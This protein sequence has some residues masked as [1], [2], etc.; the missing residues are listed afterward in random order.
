MHF[1][2]FRVLLIYSG[3]EFMNPEQEYSRRLER[4]RAEHDRA[5]QL[6]IT[7]GNIRFAVFTAAALIALLAFWR[8]A[9][10]FWWLLAPL[11][12]FIGLMIYHE[13]VDRRLRFADRAMRFYRRALARIHGEWIGTGQ[14]GERFQTKD[15]VYADDLDLFGRGSLFE[16]I[17]ET[18]TVAGEAALARW[19][20]QPAMRLEAME[21]QQA[22]DEL[23]NKLDLRED[24]ALL[25]EEI[26]AGVHAEALERWG[27]A[28][29]V[30]FHPLLRVT[31]LVLCLAGLAAFSAFMA[32]SI[33]LWP[34]LAILVLDFLFMIVV[35]KRV[36]SVVE[37]ADTPG[38]DLRILS[39]VLER[40]E[41]E[42]FETPL[43]RRLRSELDIQG[44]PASRRVARLERWMDLLDSG[45]H[46][47]VRVIRPVVL[48]TEQ[49]AMAIEAWRHVTGPHVGRWLAAI[50]DLEALS[51]L[52]AFAFERPEYAFPEL[53]DS[54]PCFEAEQINHPLLVPSKCVP[55]DV[56]LSGPLRLL[57]VSGSNMSGKSTLLRSVG[58]NAVLAWAGAPVAARRLRLSR[59]QT[60]ASIRVVDSLQD[61]KSR[62]YAEIMRLRQIV[63]VASNG[64]QVLFLL[65]EILSGTNSHDRRI[66]AAAVVRGLVDRGAIGL[67]TTHDLAL[68]ELEADLDGRAANVHFE[69]HIED[70]K[71]AFDFR[72]RPGVVSRSN[73]LELMRAIG[74]QV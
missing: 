32:Q 67:I 1:F 53:L 66:G 35:G 57:I 73:A 15:H 5:Q 30:V 49:V 43:L 17:A 26:Q 47:F 11:G 51:S 3:L 52:A 60:G 62:F 71:I 31:A 48:W 72:L 38:H 34:F 40:L 74:L 70:G 7:V 58:L 68:A 9:L 23:R 18:R 20:L 2:S 41:P 42:H 61:G 56:S 25:G 59:L 22:I 55:N 24:L 63:D 36:R 10:S 12:V 4:W 64:G 39:L 65:D 14:T 28:P 16:L 19:L 13:R 44:L 37:G 8:G 45:D 29:P 54:E 27:S 21:R 46:L 6:F 33:P 50:G 69:D